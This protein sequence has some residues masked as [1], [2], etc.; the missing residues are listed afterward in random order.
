[1]LMRDRDWGSCEVNSLAPPRLT[2]ACFVDELC[3]G[4]P[5]DGVEPW[6][7]EVKAYLQ[8]V[9]LPGSGPALASPGHRSDDG[10]VGEGPEG[11]DEEEEGG[12]PAGGEEHGEEGQPRVQVRGVASPAGARGDCSIC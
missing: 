7:H 5:T 12:N 11:H 3:T 6:V 1:M 8:E 4:L 2:I 9:E 10:N